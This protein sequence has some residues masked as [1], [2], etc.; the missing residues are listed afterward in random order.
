VRT[1]VVTGAMSGLGRASALR[2][3]ADGV[4]VVGLDI[5]PGADL[6]VD[7]TDAAAVRAAARQL[8]PVD[9]LVNS[10]GVI[11]PNLPL[12]EV[13]PADWL[14]TFAVNVNGTFHTCQ[15]FVPGMRAAGWGRIVNLASMAGKD[16]NPRLAAYS[17]TKAAV[18]GMTK[19]TAAD[20][21]AE[22]IR[23]NAICPGTV[24]S[25]SWRQRVTDQAAAAGITED[26]SRAAFVARQP[27]GRVGTPLEVADLAVYL[28]SD[29]S[30]FTTGQAHVIDG[31]WNM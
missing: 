6:V 10:A 26:E 5:T 16:G 18:I 27:M 24:D 22:G 23:V 3:A 17:A 14:R 1:A 2:L 19:A 30:S 8:G 28:A 15:A 20:F 11:G 21:V 9:I 4:R 25:P 12:W 29:E 13:D 31:G 7:V